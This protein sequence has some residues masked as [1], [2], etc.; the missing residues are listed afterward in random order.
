MKNDDLK[1]LLAAMYEN[2]LEHID[3]QENTSK[4]QVLNYLQEATYVIA[5]I[6]ESNLDSTSHAKHTFTNE[7]KKIASEGISSYKETNERFK[8]LSH[9]HEE[10]IQKTKVAC[11]DAQINLP[12]ITKKFSEIQAHMTNEVTRANLVISS[13]TQQVAQLEKK[14]NIDSLTQT[15]NRRALTAYLKDICSK[16]NIPYELHLL[17]LDLDDFKTINDRYGHIAGD[18]ILIFISN[19]LRKTLRDGDKVFRYGGEEFIIILNRIDE[20]HCKNIASRILTLVSS[21][22]LIYNGETLHVT[23]SIGAT[24]YMQNDTPDILIAR[25]DRALYKAKENGKNQICTE[26]KNGI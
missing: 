10:T 18:K 13:L 6:D 12:S 19:I 8:E 1:S 25:A 24:K 11:Q 17:I 2:L 26:V 22:N 16:K 9:Q 15:F 23:T 4:E 21:N 14:S 5:N 20:K 7:Y 3:A